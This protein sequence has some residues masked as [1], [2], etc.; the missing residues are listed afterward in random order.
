MVPSISK[1]FVTFIIW[2]SVSQPLGGSPVPGPDINYT[3]P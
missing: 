1:E 2:S 3:G